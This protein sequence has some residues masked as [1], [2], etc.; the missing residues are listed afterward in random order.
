MISFFAAPGQL[1]PGGWFG[2]TAPTSGVPPY[3]GSSTSSSGSGD[4][5]WNKTLSA[6]G[7]FLGAE[8]DR[9]KRD[10]GQKLNASGNAGA[11]E[12][13]GPAPSTQVLTLGVVLLAIVLVIVLVMRRKA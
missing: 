6:I 10:A 4:S 2:S 13:F 1:G 11:Q 9:V 8:W 7:Q 5:W 12:L 3:T